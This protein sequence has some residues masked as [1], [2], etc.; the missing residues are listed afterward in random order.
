M[1]VIL[2]VLPFINADRAEL[3]QDINYKDILQAGVT[4]VLEALDRDTIEAATE[5]SYWLDQVSSYTPGS[6]K[7]E[8]TKAEGIQRGIQYR[9]IRA[10]GGLLD[11]GYAL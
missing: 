9:G 4:G 7:V 3:F 6:E 11:H 10:R 2:P 1:L 5:F 8:R